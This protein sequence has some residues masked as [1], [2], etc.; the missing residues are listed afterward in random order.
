MTHDTE[1]TGMASKAPSAPTNGKRLT[2]P[3]IGELPQ[4][5][6]MATL[7]ITAPKF[8]VIEFKIRGNAPYVQLRFGEKAR[9]MMR[10]KQV[11]GSTGNKNKKKE[12]KDFDALYLDSMYESDEGWRGFPAS[13]IRNAAISACRIV[14]FK[15]TLA[16][17]GIWTIADGFDSKDGTALVKFTS[18]TPKHCEHPVRNATGVADL[19]VRAMWTEW[20]ADLRIRYDADMFGQSDIA[21]LVA[22]VG[23]QVGIGEG[24]PDSKAS[25]G[26][27]WGTFVI[28][29]D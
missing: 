2:I 18:G 3:A 16:K 14:G 24:R 21:N 1:V 6:E 29:N 20:T 17:L 8:N 19:R 12:G 22:R 4:D 9:E 23:M 25:A 10:A 7:V 27:G 13:S 28:A 26:M 5:S 15:M 11:A